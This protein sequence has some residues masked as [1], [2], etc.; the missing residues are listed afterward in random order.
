MDSEGNQGLGISFKMSFKFEYLLETRLH[1][2]ANNCLQYW[3]W[4][5]SGLDSS[6]DL[7]SQV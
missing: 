6:S 5:Q 4:W 3:P 1:L 7:R 2:I